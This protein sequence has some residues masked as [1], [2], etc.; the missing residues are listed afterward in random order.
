MPYDREVSRIL[1]EVQDIGSRELHARCKLVILDT[2]FEF[3]FAWMQRLVCTIELLDQAKTVLL[4]AR[5]QGNRWFQMMY[6]RSFRVE[7]HALI[8]G[9]QPTA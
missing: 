5:R 4:H 2:R 9:R 6:R 8:N 1:W 7:L 3:L